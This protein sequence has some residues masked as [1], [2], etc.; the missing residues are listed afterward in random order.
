MALEN[1]DSFQYLINKMILEKINV[2]LK[3]NWEPK[4]FNI[5]GQNGP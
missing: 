5:K 1:V 4:F 3:K 2:S